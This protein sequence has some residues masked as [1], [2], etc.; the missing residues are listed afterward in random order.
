MELGFPFIFLKD[1]DKS[2]IT[3]TDFYK[4]SDFGFINFLCFLFL[5]KLIFSLN[6][7]LYST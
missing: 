4:E 1:S 5:M 3:F 2:S 6:Y 7:F